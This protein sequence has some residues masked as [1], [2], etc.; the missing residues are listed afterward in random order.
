MTAHAAPP[1][2]E[3]MPHCPDCARRN[4]RHTAGHT[5][6]AL[7]RRA[8]TTQLRQHLG[9]IR[10][11]VRLPRFE[12][13]PGERG[14]RKGQRAKHAQRRSRHALTEPRRNTGWVIRKNE[15]GVPTTGATQH[16]ARRPCVQ[17]VADRSMAFSGLFGGKKKAPA[18][19]ARAMGEALL[20][21]V[22]FDEKEPD[23]RVG[24]RAPPPP[25]RRP[26]TP[27]LSSR[28]PQPRWPPLMRALAQGP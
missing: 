8:T 3:A 13:E 22:P 16:R 25:P 9:V 28:T 1:V 10:G 21:F 26:N 11:C 5:S 12:L 6:A 7:R 2:P 15:F 17:L 20:A 14:L 23:K 19:L 24:A 27:P 4:R 18:E